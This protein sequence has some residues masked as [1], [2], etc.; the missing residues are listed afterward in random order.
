MPS[1]DLCTS[2]AL[3]LIVK[4]PTGVHYT[5]QTGGVLCNHP[6]VEG[7]LIPCLGLSSADHTLLLEELLNHF[8]KLPYAGWGC[9]GTGLQESSAAWLDSKLATI[10]DWPPIRVDRT[11]LRQCDE[12]WIHIV[13]TVPDKPDDVLSTDLGPHFE[14]IVTWPNSD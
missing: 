13:G 14:G 3:Y 12:A 11:K 5:N 9:H 1:V 10:R 8:T 2:D 6:S 7:F 4:S